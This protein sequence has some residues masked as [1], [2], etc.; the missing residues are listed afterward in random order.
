MRK[1]LP[2]ILLLTVSGCATL[3]GLWQDSEG[4][5]VGTWDAQDQ[6]LVLTNNQTFSWTVDEGTEAPRSQTGTYMVGSTAIA[7]VVGPRPQDNFAVDYTHF[8][9]SL[10]L[11]IGPEAIFFQRRK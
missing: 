8:E 10:T 7:F 6:T 5:L 2:I 4:P 9:D 11:G 1:I 3:A